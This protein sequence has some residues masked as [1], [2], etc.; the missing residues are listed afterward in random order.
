LK[1]KK[2]FMTGHAL[3]IAL[4]KDWARALTILPGTVCVCTLKDNAIH[5]SRA[6]VSSATL[7][8]TD[9]PPAPPV[10]VREKGL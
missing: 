8:G 9:T 2:A 1:L 4:P 5:I 10:G 7:H 3:V 6:L